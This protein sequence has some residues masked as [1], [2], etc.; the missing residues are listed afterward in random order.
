MPE[1]TVNAVPEQLA[2]VMNFV[3]ERLTALGCSNKVRFNC[4][5]ANNCVSTYEIKPKY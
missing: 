1:M 2:P 3:N 5:V 4:Q